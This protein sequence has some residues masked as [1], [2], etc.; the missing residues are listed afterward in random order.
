M[1]AVP[2]LATF[3]TVEAMCILY[4]SMLMFSLD[5]YTAEPWYLVTSVTLISLRALVVAETCKSK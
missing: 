2:S 5:I 4:I 1:P 3:M